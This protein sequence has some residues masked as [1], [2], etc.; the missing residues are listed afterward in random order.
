MRRKWLETGL[1]LSVTLGP[2]S[3]KAQYT[4]DFQTN[5]INGVTSNWSGTY[6]VGD[7]NANDVLIIQN[8]GQLSV[9]PSGDGGLGATYKSSNNFVLVTGPGSLWKMTYGFLMLSG[10]DD[11]CSA[12][13]GNGMVIS[14]GGVVVSVSGYIGGD[15]FNAPGSNSVLVSDPGSAWEMPVG[16]F[17]VGDISTM[18]SLVISN[19]GAVYDNAGYLGLQSGSG[20][21]SA[22]VTGTGSVWSN[23]AGLEIG[24]YGGPN[25]LMIVNGGLVMSMYGSIGARTSSNVVI[26]SGA[27]SVWTNQGDVTVGGFGSGNM[28]VISNGGSLYGSNLVVGTVGEGLYGSNLVESSVGQGTLI[29]NGGSIT[30]TGFFATNAQSMVTFNAGLIN[31]VQTIV[32]NGPVFAVGDGVQAATFLMSGGSNSFA[33]NLWIRTNAQLNGCAT[34]S[35]ATVID[36]TLLA[37]C[38]GTVTFGGSLTNNGT[39]LVQNGTSLDLYGPAVNNGLI[40]ATNGA[41]LGYGSF[42][43]NGTFL[44]V[45][46]D[47]RDVWT[48]SSGG[49]W[50]G[51]ANWSQGAPTNDLWCLITNPASRTVTIDAVTVSAHPE[52][53]AVDSLT[54]GGGA[55]GTNILM[56]SNPGTGTPFQV[57]HSLTVSSTGKL[58]VT[59]GAIQIGALSGPSLN[60]DGVISMAA[61][62]LTVTN[63]PTMVGVNGAGLLTASNSIVVSGDVSLGGAAGASGTW[64]VT[65]AGSSWSNGGTAYLGTGGAGDQLIVN[66]G[67]L[68]ITSYADIGCASSTSNNIAQVSGAGSVWSNLYDLSVG[69]S[70]VSN[71]L[72]VSSG[73]AVFGNNGVIGS[74]S[75]AVANS[76]ILTD[77]GSVWSNR[78]GLG[79]GVFGASNNLIVSNGAWLVSGYSK[80]YSASN[81]IGYASNNNQILVCGTGSVWTAFTAVNIGV[82]GAGNSLVIS[83]GGQ[84]TSPVS[85]VGLAAGSSNNSILV[86]GINSL[87]TNSNSDGGTIAVGYSGD[88]N[89][90]IITNGAQVFGYSTWV[91]YNAT[92]SNNS[93]VVSGT[94]TTWYQMGGV[95]LG[96]S[97]GN[98]RLRAADG[99][100]MIGGRNQSSSFLGL[101]SSSSNNTALVTGVGTVWS[102]YSSIFVGNG[103]PGNNLTISNGAHVFDLTTTLG[104]TTFS[105]NNSLLVAG[106]GSM[107]SNAASLY[108]GYSGSGNTL[109]LDN[110][111]AVVDGTVFVGNTSASSNNSVKVAGGA[112]WQNGIVYVGYQGSSN[113]LLISG[114]SVS[115][116]SIVVGYNSS[117]CNNR[118]EMDNG[119]LVVTNAATNAVLE[120]RDGMVI[121]NSGTLLADELVITNACALFLRN[122]G[123]LT[124][125]TLVLNPNTSAVGDGIPN[126][127]KQ[128]YGLDPLDPNLANRDLD[129]TGLTVLQDYLAG[130][131]PTD[132]NSEFRITAIAPVG[133]DMRI[134]FTSV[135][136]R[137]YL[138]QRC[139]FMGGA[140][141]SIVTNIPGNGAIQWAKD[142]GGATRGS[143][144]YRIELAQLT[145]APPL[146]SDGDGLPDLWTEAYFGHPTGQ[147]NDLSCAAC[148]F[149]GTGQNNFFKYVAGL[150]P[151]NPASVFVF[152]IASVTNQP[153]QNNLFFTPLALG[154]TY[155]PQYSTDLTSGV[156]LPL[157]TYT[158]LLTN[159]NQ[160]TMTDTNPIPP[161]EFYRIG[162]S[163]P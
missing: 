74:N 18:N 126:G 36:G 105:A 80:S 161:Q 88:G 99:C 107:L 43:N 106:P 129:G 25:N 130:I 42:Q 53:L 156:W 139:D 15:V 62:R 109:A 118:L 158:P 30:V 83:N 34:V 12:G 153:P 85:T 23:G 146:D 63:G 75:T 119:S 104:S 11:C 44:G 127:W 120:V 100:T 91:G 136:G 69:F 93:V 45:F 143:G 131:S 132:P 60:I 76:A 110:G 13:P 16:E 154:R 138:M 14:N 29:L 67:A 128:Q 61:A 137:Y 141:T 79:V 5:I 123:T 157:T 54:V 159:G 102:N 70:G 149:D 56:L 98:N 10:Q 3:S 96:Y 77:P 66:Q 111:G 41:L 121:L 40:I 148:D 82:Q 135:S 115:A 145:N 81:N 152:Y 9:D 97:G 8:G 37:D 155:T 59:N 103:G 46:Q 2:L 57:Q 151:T 163:L 150:N 134:Y 39:L 117:F 35:G 24:S 51:P 84:V 78:F 142:I 22:W 49:K 55:S 87:W 140:W 28:L 108:V 20:F 112:L 124:I 89:S 113:S 160:L 52:T 68:L 162:I 7:T 38:G 116:S 33:N 48:N 17:A 4:F 6:Y 144:F 73:A 114:G 122:G 19:G 32:S 133:A 1:L 31:A 125:H 65:G 94:G 101:N 64:M 95:F 92:S 26:V 58:I 50:E 86:T 47:M 71:E 90:L 147:S 72:V 27:G 21:N